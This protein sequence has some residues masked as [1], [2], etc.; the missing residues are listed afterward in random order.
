M[1]KL[2]EIYIQGRIVNLDNTEIGKLEDYLKSVQDE[3][4][5]LKNEL[6]EILEEIYN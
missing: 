5:K 3:K 4:S 1:E 6:D 2:G